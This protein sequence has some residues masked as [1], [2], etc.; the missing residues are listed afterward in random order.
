[1]GNRRGGEMTFDLRSVYLRVPVCVR[2]RV[3]PL[4]SGRAV[5]VGNGIQAP[6][7]ASTLL[8]LHYRG[9][10]FVSLQLQG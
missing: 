6:L 2:T 4:S 5:V 9:K 10:S 3:S 1:M 8:I 7:P